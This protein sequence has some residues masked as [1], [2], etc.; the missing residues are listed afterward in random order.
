MKCIHNE[1]W[2][3]CF[4]NNHILDE[5]LTDNLQYVGRIVSYD[6]DTTGKLTGLYYDDYDV[7]YGIRRIDGKMIYCSCVGGITPVR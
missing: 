4:G 7:Y 3:D 2:V 5:D 6:H 1:M